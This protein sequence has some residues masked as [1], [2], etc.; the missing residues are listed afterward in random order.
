MFGDY[1]GWSVAVS[2][3]TVV[4][5]A[6][7]D[8][9]SADT[10]GS[11]YVFVRSAGGWS[12][13]AKLTMPRPPLGFYTLTP[14][15]LVDTRG[16]PGVP[17]GGPALQGQ[18]TRQFW[19]RDYGYC[20][21]PAT[22]RAL[23]L[24]V[25]VTAPT[26]AGNVRLFPGGTDLPTVSAINYG[27]GQTRASNVVIGYFHKIAAFVGQPAGTTVHLILDVNGYFE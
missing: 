21:I 22:A 14:C 1:F 19:V 5:G 2:G 4:G 6:P 12:Q 16:T 15:R 9:I 25:T 18:E 11:A 24:N 20:G 23:S 7:Q 26:A 17:I 8:Q 3:D 10:Q 27:T 13:Q